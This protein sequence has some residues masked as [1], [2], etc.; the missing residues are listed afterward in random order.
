MKVMQNMDMGN[1]KKVVVFTYLL[2]FS[3]V[4][5]HRLF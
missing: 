2:L 4:E 3:L 5:R 1:E